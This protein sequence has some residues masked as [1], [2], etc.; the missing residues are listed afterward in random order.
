MRLGT[1]AA[2][3]ILI[4]AFDGIGTGTTTALATFAAA[5]V[6][7]GNISGGC[8]VVAVFVFVFWPLLVLCCFNDFGRMGGI[9]GGGANNVIGADAL[10]I[11]GKP[12]CGSWTRWGAKMDGPTV[13]SAAGWLFCTPLFASVLSGTTD[14]PARAYG[15]KFAIVVVGWSQEEEEV[16]G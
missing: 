12:F 1:P 6:V 3:V 16:V 14:E 11:V 13:A 8:F 2:V 7:L 15:T 10:P 4:P 9:P 5:P